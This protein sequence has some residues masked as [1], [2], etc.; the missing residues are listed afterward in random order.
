M[1]PGS[2]RNPSARA[3]AN[4]AS[5]LVAMSPFDVGLI[6]YSLSSVIYTGIVLWGNHI[7]RAPDVR[8]DCGH[9]KSAG[10]VIPAFNAGQSADCMSQTLTE[11]QRL[12]LDAAVVDDGS[13]EPLAMARLAARDCGT[14]NLLRHNRNRGKA[15]A[16]GT[17][18]AALTTDVIV[19][20]DAD[21]ILRERDFRLA[22]NSFSDGGLGALA[23]SLSVAPGGGII[24]WVQA[25]EYRCVLD[26]ERRALAALGVVFTVPGAASLWRRAALQQIGG[27]SGRTMSEDT[28]ATIGLRCAGW[29]IA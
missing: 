28:D 22:L 1:A 6:M 20:V 2:D 8:E 9:T 4:P 10:L 15:A 11:A 3:I 13:I 14:L 19:T 18:I 27:F 21:T 29:R 17:G 24:Q 25:L 23:M 16:L 26:F 7:S 5:S 12:G